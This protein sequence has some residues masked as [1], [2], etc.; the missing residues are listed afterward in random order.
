M[1]KFPFFIHS[2]SIVSHWIHGTS[3]K[4]WD[5]LTVRPQNTKDPAPGSY[6]G[7]PSWCSLPSGKAWRRAGKPGG[8]P[9]LGSREGSPGGRGTW[10]LCWWGPSKIGR[11]L[12]FHRFCVCFYDFY[13]KINNTTFGEGWRSNMY[14]F[15]FKFIIL[16]WKGKRLVTCTICVLYI[17]YIYIYSTPKNDRK[18]KC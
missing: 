5:Q 16:V 17:M 12:I 15:Q 4:T 7:G 3:P 1:D 10:K 8:K 18:G 13:A 14:K 2:L 11:S 9:G 6:T